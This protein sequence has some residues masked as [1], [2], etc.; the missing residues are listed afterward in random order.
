MA[1][2]PAI[3]RRGTNN[4]SNFTKKTTRM[5]L[6]MTGFGKATGTF[7]SK[8]ISVEVRSLN[9][10]SIDLNA[11]IH[12]YYKELEPLAR[13]VVAEQ[14]ERGK[15]DLF[16]N[17]DSTGESKTYSINADLANAYFKDLEKI[18]AQIGQQSQ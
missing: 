17:L 10:K 11:R 8:K 1:S 2:A 15:V 13:K 5:L 4:F 12:H 3:N 7:E 18:N 9:S 16:I 6:S 14:L